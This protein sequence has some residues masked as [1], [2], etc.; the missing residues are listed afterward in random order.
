LCSFHAVD[1]GLQIKILAPHIVHCIVVNTSD[2]QHFQRS[3]LTDDVAMKTIVAAMINGTKE[4]NSAVRCASE[5]A[6]CALFDISTGGGEHTRYTV[7]VHARAFLKQA[8]MQEYA[9]RV[10]E[11]GAHDVLN[12][13]YAKTLL[14]VA[15]Q[16]GAAI[17]AQA[18]TQLDDTI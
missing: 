4:K 16:R 11:P 9:S 7:G 10:S 8:R 13:V 15:K 3:L 2:E 5:D 6:L 12:E 18:P 17:I 14:K 1:V